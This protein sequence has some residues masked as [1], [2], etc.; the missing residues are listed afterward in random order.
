M[1]R[2][3]DSARTDGEMPEGREEAR[4]LST[5]NYGHE[6]DEWWVLLDPVEEPSS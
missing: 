3:R 2:N 4:E 5:S 1:K 6:H